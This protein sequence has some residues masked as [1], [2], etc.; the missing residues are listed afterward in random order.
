MVIIFPWLFHD[1]WMTKSKNS[2]T[3]Y[4]TYGIRDMCQ[5]KEVGCGR[6]NPVWLGNQFKWNVMKKIK[7]SSISMLDISIS[8][9]WF[10]G[11]K[12]GTEPWGFERGCLVISMTFFWIF[13]N[14]ESNSMT[15]PGLEKENEIPWL[16]Q[17]FHDWI[18]PVLVWLKRVA[19]IKGK[20]DGHW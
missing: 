1:F 18:H 15:F 12:R 8:L 7:S 11:F 3:F 13:Q 20:N 4:M 2:M 19:L 10:V 5:G 14:L 16:F 9:W 6:P 17:V